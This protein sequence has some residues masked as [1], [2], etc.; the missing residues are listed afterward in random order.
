MIRASRALNDDYASFRET[1]DHNVTVPVPDAG[2]REI[3]EKERSSGG[4]AINGELTAKH[5]TDEM[6]LFYELNPE[7]RRVS[8]PET[9]AEEFVASA[10]DTLGIVQGEDAP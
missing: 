1:Y 8:R 4:F 7:L 6:T 5:W 9:I 10:L 3:W 2:I